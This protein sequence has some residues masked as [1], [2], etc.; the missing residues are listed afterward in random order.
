MSLQCQILTEDQK[1]KIHSESIRILGEVGAKFLS[2]KALQI[3]KDNGAK[4]DTD[5]QIARIPEEMVQQALETAPKS[6]VLGSRVKENDFQ[7]PSS[8]SGYVLD[9]GGIFTR[10][11]KT[12]ERRRCNY[13]DHIDFLRVFDEMKLASVIWPAS[14]HEFPDQSANLRE[15]I[16][17]F[18]YSTCHIQDE[19]TH[20]AE[21]PYMV[22]AMVA[23]LGSE[24]AVR[25]RHLYS[26]VYCTLAPLKHEGGMCDA[27]LELIQVDAPICIF[28]MPC[29]GSTGPASLFSNIAMGNAEALSALTLFQMARPGTPIIFGDASGS[30]NFAA[31]NFLEGTPEMVLQTGAR[32][33]MARFYHLP[34]TQAGCL[35]DAKD[36][37]SQAVMEKLVTTLPLVML[38][39]DLV[40]GPGALE[41]SNMMTLEQIVVDDEIAC[42]CKRLKDGV[43]MSDA[44]NYF[45]DIKD[46]K[47]GGH[48]LAQPNT[49]E[50]C[51]SSEFFMP[52][53]AD[54]NTFEQ[55][56][57]LGR[58]DIYDKAREK[59]E[60]ILASPQ[61]N[62]PPDDVIGKL[63]DIMRRA[64]EELKS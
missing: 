29:A 4:V 44:R 49:I 53:L 54:R 21:V 15:D 33:E 37:G 64:D 55:W 48:F 38:G 3:L 50:A 36:H 45:E 24:D 42:L 63:E 7:L 39:V 18:I 30:T 22:E 11:F 60:E 13:Q 58:P 57:E 20:P 46:V 59:V 52:Q 27:Y 47:P 31:G 43:D 2:E 5:T 61:K 26:V 19:L 32:G 51:R 14:V 17:S 10:D 40:Q 12:G 9:N 16:S 1:Q 6:F 8:Y 56:V 28:P 34:D 41:T 35:T 23:I 25:Q 62:P